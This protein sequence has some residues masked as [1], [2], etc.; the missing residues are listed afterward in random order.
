MCPLVLNLA[1][2]EG[3]SAVFLSAE[4][5]S[6]ICQIVLDGAKKFFLEFSP[7]MPRAVMVRLSGAPAFRYLFLLV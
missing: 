6:D 4:E 5:E 1:L 7:P 3:P 2:Q